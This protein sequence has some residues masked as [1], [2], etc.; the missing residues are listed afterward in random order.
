[1]QAFNCLV[2]LEGL[3]RENSHLRELFISAKRGCGHVRHVLHALD[4]RPS[5]NEDFS[6]FGLLL[7]EIYLFFFV[8]IRFISDAKREFRLIFFTFNSKDYLLVNKFIQLLISEV[9]A[10]V[11]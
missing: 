5:N 10:Q 8:Y 2:T 6:K 3:D 11:L 1:M 4:V 9:I 7:F